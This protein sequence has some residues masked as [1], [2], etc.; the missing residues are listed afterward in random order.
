MRRICTV[1]RSD[2]PARSG[3]LLVGMSLR[4]GAS[5]RKC[6]YV[7]PDRNLVRR[8][9]LTTKVP[10]TSYEKGE[11][12]DRNKAAEPIVVHHSSEGKKSGTSGGFIHGQR[13]IM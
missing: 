2:T 13:I 10:L 11:T 12:K 7:P 6:P 4:R 8:P 9:G 1:A 5:I 3:S